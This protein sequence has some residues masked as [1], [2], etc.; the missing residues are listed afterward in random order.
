MTGGRLF[1]GVHHQATFE[2][3]ENDNDYHIKILSADHE[4]QIEVEGVVCEEVPNTS[5]FDSLEDASNFFAAG[6]LGYSPSHTPGN[7]E[8]IELKTNQWQMEAMDI[9]KVSSSFFNQKNQFP[10]GSIQFDSALIMRHLE[11]EWHN[12]GELCISD[13]SS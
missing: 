12:R 10:E 1:P 3:N 13:C 4:V 11:H 2:V 5:V 9:S 7:F 8:G 6:S